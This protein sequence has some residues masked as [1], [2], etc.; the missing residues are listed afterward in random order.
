MRRIDR[1]CIESGLPLDKR[2]SD[3]DF[4]AVS[5]VSKTHIMALA[6]GDS[7]LEQGANLLV[8]GPPGVG[9]THLVS[10]IGHELIARGCRVLFTRTS[11]LVQ[12]LQ[13]E[14]RDLRLPAEL[15]KLDRFDLLICDDYS[16]VRRDQAENSPLSIASSITPA[17]SR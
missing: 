5:T 6:E 13:A 8:F 17:S 14:R 9:K 12:R 1:H 4:A 7:W 2:L 10:S 11:D 3:F 15:S 16:Y